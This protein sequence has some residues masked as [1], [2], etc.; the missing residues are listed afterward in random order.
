MERERNIVANNNA[1]KNGIIEIQ[2]VDT[3]NL[4]HQVITWT[5]S[6]YQTKH[7]AAVLN[8]PVIFAVAAKNDIV[9]VAKVEVDA[10]IRNELIETLK[11]I[12]MRCMTWV[13]EPNIAV[14]RFP[15]QVLVNEWIINL[16]KTMSILQ[17]HSTK[18]LKWTV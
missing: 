17:L 7:H 11:L 16:S 10:E 14:S 15:S 5:P 1:C 4:L 12:T 3:I 2:N 8:I 13:T 6:R 9:H 18:W